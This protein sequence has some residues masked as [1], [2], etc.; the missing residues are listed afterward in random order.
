MMVFLNSRSCRLEYD[1]DAS[2]PGFSPLSAKGVKLTIGAKLNLNLGLKLT[3]ETTVVVTTEVPVVETERTQV[4]STIDDRAVADLPTNGRNFIDFVLLTGGVNRDVRQGDLSFAGQRGTLN[5]LTVDGTD[6]NNTF[7]GQTLG[8]TGSGRA[9]YQFSQDAVQEFQVNTNGYSAE[10]GRAGGA[11]INVITKSGTNA[12]HG[13]GF[14]FFRDRGLNANDPIYDLQFASAV[15][16]GR[17]VPLKPG[18]HFNQFGGNVGGPIV[19]DRTFFF[20]DYDGQ[21]NNTGNP[22]LVTLPTPANAFQTA[23]VNFLAARTNSY[24]RTFDQNVYLG[25]IDHNFNSHNQLSGRY[26][27]QR[28]QG[29][30]QENSG[31]TSAFEHTGASNVNTDTVSLQETAESTPRLLNVANFSYQRDNEPGLANS[32]NP[33]AT[34]R[35]AGQTL[36]TIGRNSFSPRETTIHR[37]QYGD[38]I[39]WLRGRHTFKFGGDILH[40]S[41]LNFFPGN[42]SGSYTFNSLDDFGRSLMGLPVTAA[43]N[44]LVEAYPGAGTTGATTHPNLLQYAA[45]VQDDWKITRGLTLNLGVRYD[46]GMIAQPSV[47]NPAALAAGFDTSKIP[48]DYNNVAPRLGFAWQPIAGRQFVIRSGYGIFYATTPAIMYGTAH[49]NNGINVQTLTFNAS[50]ATPLPASYPNVTCG[51]PTQNAGC[52]LPGG[53]ALPAPTIYVFNRNYVQPYVQQFN[54][55]V[56]HQIG[57]DLS[58]SVGYLGVRGVH[59]QRTRDINEPVTEVPTVFTVAGTGQ[60]LTVNRLTGPRPFARFGRIFEFESNANSIYH[61]LIFQVNKRFAHN[62]QAF[63][64]YT[65]SHVIDNAPDATAVVPV[66]DDGKLVFDPNHIALDRSTGNDDVRHRFVFSGIWDLNYA[67]GIQNSVLKTLAEGWQ[68]AAIFNAQSGQPY[69]ALVNADLNNDG[70]SRN[71]R[72]PGFGRNTFTMPAIVSLDPRVTR[73]IRITERVKLQF[74]GEAFNVLNHQNITGVR[75]TLFAANTVTHVL[76]PQNVSTAGIAAFG[77]P[78]SAN[79]NGQGNVGRVIQL[80]AKVSF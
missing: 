77:L 62:F 75:N 46:V 64:S 1:I 11:V 41:I 47:Q 23:A 56:E 51:A 69:S 50:A 45:F 31:A 49:S 13:T 14:E 59:I 68:M 34:V 7:F 36:S 78:S 58:V 25:K 76:T 2:K 22:I 63:G 37:Q 18:Y 67:Q 9:P 32:I 4:S 35:N 65:W 3:S 21:R 30:A 6:N 57:K 5:S 16:A 74:I 48:N 17:P 24:N 54:L 29:Q 53:A 60:A 72:A 79:V 70:N 28:F 8:R 71:E 19:K 38:T 43:G 39:T 27:A 52:P 61:G 66:T 12:F 33:E 44:S 80:A 15:V 42:F 20:F 55:G 73:T 10:F 26:N 40:D